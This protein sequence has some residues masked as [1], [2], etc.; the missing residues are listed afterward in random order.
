[1]PGSNRLEDR[2]RSLSEELIKAEGEDFHG[3]AAELRTA[4]SEHIERIRGKL[5]NYPSSGDRRTPDRNS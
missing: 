4:L 1:M 2:I 3:L 5:D